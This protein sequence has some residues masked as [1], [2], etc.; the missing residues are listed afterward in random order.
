MIEINSILLEY[1][2]ISEVFDK[3]KGVNNEDYL[4]RY[5]KRG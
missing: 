2:G 5:S 1:I 3:L 4:I